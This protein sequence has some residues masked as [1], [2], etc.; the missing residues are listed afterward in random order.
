MEYSHS[1][2]KLQNGYIWNTCNDILVS[3]VRSQEWPCP[4]CP[5]SIC[6]GSPISSYEHVWLLGPLVLT[7]YTM[8]YIRHLQRCH[9]L[10]ADFIDCDNTSISFYTMELVFIYEW[11]MPTFLQI[12]SRLN[13]IDISVIP[14]VWT[15]ILLC[16]LFWQTLSLY[17]P[18]LQKVGLY[19]SGRVTRNK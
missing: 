8:S 12:H 5:V 17:L 11:V 3:I 10:C 19:Y 1:Y 9:L 4:Q 15:L 6:I 18:K 2:D 13:R 7:S 14:R 16:T